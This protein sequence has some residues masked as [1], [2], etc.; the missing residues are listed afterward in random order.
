MTPIDWLENVDLDWFKDKEIDKHSRV[1]SILR[2]NEYDEKFGFVSGSLAIGLGL[3]SIKFVPIIF[4]MILINVG[5]VTFSLTF[6]YF[7][8]FKSSIKEYEEI[9]NKIKEEKLDLIVNELPEGGSVYDFLNEI[10]EDRIKEY[11]KVLLASLD[12]DNVNEKYL[13]EYYK[14]EEVLNEKEN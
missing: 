7:F 11:K 10:V 14:I 4:P 13:K 5:I 12:N 8:L 6:A 2:K 1:L 9:K 3:L